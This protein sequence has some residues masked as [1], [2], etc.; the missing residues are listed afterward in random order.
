[1]TGRGVAGLGVV[2]ALVAGCLGGQAAAL[3][4]SEKPALSVSGD[5][6]RRYLDP[7]F[8]FELVRPVGNWRLEVTDEAPSDGV[9]VPLVLREADVGTQVV[10]Q[11]AP[12]V[13][14]PSEFAVR[15][16]TGLRHHPGFIASE[17]AVLAGIQTAVGF[18]FTLGESI[19][20]R[21][22]VADGGPGQ[23]F[24]M[25]ATWPAASTGA[26]RDVEEIF[27]SLRPV[28]RG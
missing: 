11:V 17:P 3:R 19:H 26:A 4:P 24:M 6:G 18:G 28:P 16:V 1:M 8:G 15:L 7:V 23:V 27:K 25:M 12:A 21:V 20:G 13:A 14:S 9:A 22:V 5:I 2:W 10:V